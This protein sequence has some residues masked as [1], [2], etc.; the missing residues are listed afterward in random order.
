MVNFAGADLADARL[1]GS[2]LYEAAFRDTVLDGA[3]WN[4]AIIT[5][6]RLALP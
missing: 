2:N 1:D 3:T 6:T 5:K 4:D